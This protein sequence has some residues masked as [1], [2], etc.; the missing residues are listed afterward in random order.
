MISGEMGLRVGAAG[1]LDLLAIGGL[2]RR[3]QS[4]FGVSLLGVPPPDPDIATG[5]DRPPGLWSFW[6][7]IGRYLSLKARI[8]SRWAA[9]SREYTPWA[10]AWTS[11]ISAALERM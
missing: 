6:S 2:G 10:S 7:R 3:A 8:R 9:S 4:S 5:P 11:P 1:N